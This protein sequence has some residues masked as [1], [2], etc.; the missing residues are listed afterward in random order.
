MDR[1][2][3]LNSHGPLVLFCSVQRLAPGWYLTAASSRSLLNSTGLVFCLFFEVV[4]VLWWGLNILSVAF[5][6]FLFF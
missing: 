3:V 2:P 1:G 5:F 4:G 6:S